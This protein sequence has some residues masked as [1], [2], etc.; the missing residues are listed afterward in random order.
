MKNLSFFA[1][2]FTKYLFH[3]TQ[4]KERLLIATLFI[5]TAILKCNQLNNNGVSKI[6]F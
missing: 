4:E 5:T 1:F 3:G 6:D 2:L